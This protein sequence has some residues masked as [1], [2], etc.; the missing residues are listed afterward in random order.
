MKKALAMI[1]LL[2][3]ALPGLSG[4]KKKQPDGTTE[5]VTQPVTESETASEQ[6]ENKT[7]ADTTTAE[8]T[9]DPSL[10]F[11]SSVYGEGWAVAS[12]AEKITAD[13]EK[14]LLF[15]EKF[16]YKDGCAGNEMSGGSFDLVSRNVAGPAENYRFEFE[17]LLSEPD[18]ADEKATV[19][20]GLR[21][22]SELIRP[23]E[24]ASGIWLA[25]GSDSI[26]V[27]GGWDKPLTKIKLPVGFT[28][29]RRVAIEDDE[30]NNVISVYVQTD[31]ETM[32]LVCKIK[33]RAVE[34]LTV[35]DV[36][37]YTDLCQS[38]FASVEQ[39]ELLYTGGVCKL[40]NNGRSET[41]VRNAAYLTE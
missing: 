32:L 40:W 39:E 34:G 36:Y 8:E 1:L 31:A 27:Y 20:V 25:V 11:P 23:Q 41:Y 2:S 16:I 28:D 22:Q 24:P 4:C 5:S 33:P 37:S 21:V 3:L 38:V 9:Y 13:D 10:I 7:V 12:L 15:S 30:W 29:F 18:G 26:G 19:F 6:T 14:W 17:L 35:L